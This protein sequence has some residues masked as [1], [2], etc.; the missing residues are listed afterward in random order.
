MPA[1]LFDLD[2]VLVDTAKYHFLA[3]REVCRQLGFDLTHQQN[4]KLKGIDRKTSLS[5]L[6]EMGGVTLDEKAFNHWLIAKNTHYLKL[7]EQLKPSDVF[8]GVIS[9]FKQ[10][11]E[12]NIKIGLGSASKNARLILDKL[13]ITSQFDAIIDGNLTTHGKPNPEVFLKGAEACDT[14]PGECIVFEDAEAGI[15]AAKNGGMK[16]VAIGDETQ[17]ELADKVYPHISKVDLDDVLLLL[18]R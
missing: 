9:L 11:Q 10:L 13:D 2:G 18:E 14:L 16:A 3:W 17:F 12:K 4:E 15:E 1:F 5:I 8:V 6:L 7:I